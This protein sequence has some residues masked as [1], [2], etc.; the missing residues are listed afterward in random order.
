MSHAQGTSATRPRRPV[1]RIIVIVILVLPL[2]GCCYAPPGDN[3]I[4]DAPCHTRLLYYPVE[5]WRQR[6]CA[7]RRFVCSSALICPRLG[8]L[9]TP[10]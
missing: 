2:L 5:V 7:A 1:G 9:V 4:C 3:S 10:P 8:S 6:E